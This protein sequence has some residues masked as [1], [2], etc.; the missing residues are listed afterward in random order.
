MMIHEAYNI[1]YDMADPS[2]AGVVTK[3]V[4]GRWTH[5][6]MPLLLGPLCATIWPQL[7]CKAASLFINVN[8]IGELR[9]LSII[10]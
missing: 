5:S 9:R 4:H 1:S 3:E 7:T 2:G 6:R 8:S 10:G